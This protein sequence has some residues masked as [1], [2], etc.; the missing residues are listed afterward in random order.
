MEKGI[1]K[2]AKF[3]GR[4]WPPFIFIGFVV[5]SGL[6]LIILKLQCRRSLP[7]QI[8]RTVPFE[9][10][11]D[12]MQ[13]QQLV[14]TKPNNSIKPLQINVTSPVL[15]N[16]EVQIEDNVNITT[17]YSEK[18]VVPSLE[19]IN[20]KIPD[21]NQSPDKVYLK[22]EEMPQFMGGH[23]DKFRD[24]VQN[25]LHYPEIA[26]E[27]GISG[28]VAIRFSVNNRGEVCDVT[29]MRS[30]D[31]TLDSEAVRVISSSPRW[32]PG[33]IKGKPVKV[34]YYVP[35]AFALK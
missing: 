26:A 3:E 22:A 1:D 10:N 33:K 14:E 2:R 28:Q 17:E 18:F 13:T 21:E 11:T 32:I 5:I 27:N 34:Q 9:F 6:I 30:V 31:P 25:H 19:K 12:V 20:T 24:W 15:A 29:V 35:V 16:N 4:Q 7:E 23:C 8:T